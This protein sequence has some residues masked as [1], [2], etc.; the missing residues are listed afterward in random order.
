MITLIVGV[1]GSGKTWFAVEKLIPAKLRASG[2]RLASNIR[3]HV[4]ADLII[5]DDA[6]ITN[7]RFDKKLIVLD[8]V[9]FVALRDKKNEMFQHFTVHRHTQRE[10]LWIT[11]SLS[12]LP[13]KWLGLVERTIKVSPVAG[14]ATS[15]AQEYLGLPRV[16]D[17]PVNST[18]FRPGPTDKY[19]TVETGFE[20][21]KRRVPGK[22]IALSIA[23]IASVMAAP[24]MIGYAYQNF[25]GGELFKLTAGQQSGGFLSLSGS[26][27]EADRLSSSKPEAQEYQESSDSESSD[28][29]EDPPTPSSIVTFPMDYEASLKYLDA[30]ESV[31]DVYDCRGEFFTDNCNKPAPQFDRHNLQKL[32]PRQ[33]QAARL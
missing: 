6:D 3:G 10:Y 32:I 15:R 16:I 20:T 25:G 4:D 11:Q 22:V 14:S 28:D 31:A 30:P 24:L 17:L 18:M 26:G 19:Q 7:P 9:Q 27:D 33:A 12:A 2:L 21:M 23:L 8:E 5:D 13:K 29:A 1:P